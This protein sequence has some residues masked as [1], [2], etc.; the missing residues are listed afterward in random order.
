[1]SEKREIAELVKG[2]HGLTNQIYNHDM[3]QGVFL[4]LKRET[5]FPPGNYKD[6]C[7]E[8]VVKHSKELSAEESD[9]LELDEELEY[10]KC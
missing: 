3:D 10:S 7:D 9:A 8:C 6:T 2:P 4:G 1:M 5:Q